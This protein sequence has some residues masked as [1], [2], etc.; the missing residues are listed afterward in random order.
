MS[1]GIVDILNNYVNGTSNGLECVDE[2]LSDNERFIHFMKQKRGDVTDKQVEYNINRTLNEAKINMTYVNNEF[3]IKIG[4]TRREIKEFE[5]NYFRNILSSALK[6]LNNKISHLKNNIDSND[7]TVKKQL[8]A[9]NS[10]LV[11]MSTTSSESSEKL[12]TDISELKKQLN[13]LDLNPKTKTEEIVKLEKSVQQGLDDLAVLVAHSTEPEVAKPD[14]A[15]PDDIKGGALGIINLSDVTMSN[16]PNNIKYQNIY[17]ETALIFLNAFEYKIKDTNGYKEIDCENNLIKD[18]NLK[19]FL[20][21]LA[22]KVNA[23]PTALNSDMREKE[24]KKGTGNW[25]GDWNK[26]ARIAVGKRSQ[27]NVDWDTVQKNMSINS[28]YAIPSIQPSWSGVITGGTTEP[29][30]TPIKTPKLSS[31]VSRVL[32]S[33][34]NNLKSKGIE[35]TPSDKQELEN[36][37]KT[38][39]NLEKIILEK[40]AIPLSTT[41]KNSSDPSFNKTGTYGINQLE[42]INKQFEFEKRKYMKMQS[43]FEK[44]IFALLKSCQ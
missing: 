12:A 41:D 15:K 34:L 24:F 37:L 40:Y 42:H 13:E 4:S 7:T 29:L 44:V 36:K 20:K 6:D 11:A 18:P 5:D 25:S 21:N 22:K 23:T 9:I 35:L 28:Y 39:Q 38:F 32:I 30:S 26:F 19:I 1:K 14:D 33:I 43:G 27:S 2:T 31:D 10:Q 17:I 16:D 8:D 3:K